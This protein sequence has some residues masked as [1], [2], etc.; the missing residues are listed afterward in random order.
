MSEEASCL[1]VV[2]TSGAGV[3]VVLGPADASDLRILCV[4]MYE[5]EAADACF[6]RHCIAFCQAYSQWSM[7]MSAAASVVLIVTAV[8]VMSRVF[9]R[10][11]AFAKQL[12]DVAF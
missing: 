9:M 3:F 4:R 2:E 8:C 5:Y 1:F 11:A 6:R 12:K 7:L 10:S